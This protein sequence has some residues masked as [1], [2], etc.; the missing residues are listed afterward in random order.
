MFTNY[1][2]RA[3]TFAKKLDVSRQKPKNLRFSY[4]YLTRTMKSYQ[5]Y[6]LFEL[7]WPKL[8]SF[9]LNW[10]KNKAMFQTLLQNPPIQVA[11]FAVITDGLG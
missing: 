5:W 8:S 2:T 4:H 10:L 6:S 11:G 7:N 3:N 1:L 9:E